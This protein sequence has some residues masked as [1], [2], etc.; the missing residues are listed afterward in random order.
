MKKD[1]RN[2][3]IFSFVVVGLLLI[4]MFMSYSLFESIIAVSVDSDIAKWNIKVNNE[5][6]TNGSSVNNTFDIGSISWQNG[7]HVISGKAAPGSVGSFAIEVDPVDTQVSFTY[8]IEFD[9]TS[10][11]NDKF[12][13]SNVREINGHDF[14]RVA[15][16]TYVGIARLSEINN[17][18]LYEVDIDISWINDD[19]NN[20]ND[21]QIG[22]NGDVGVYIPVNID[23]N[24]YF[25]TEVF[26]PYVE[27]GTS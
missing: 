2:T 12:V 21:Y 9:L 14:I 18:D 4:I 24:Q 20:D 15:E 5:M 16:N 26:T 11:H 23:V 27:G 7:G 19:N 17:G 22:I 8:Q 3:L 10:L 6:I 13:I 25:G 1:T